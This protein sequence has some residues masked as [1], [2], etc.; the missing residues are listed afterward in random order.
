MCYLLEK[1]VKEIIRDW[2]TN[3]KYMIYEKYLGLDLELV[4][5]LELGWRLELVLELEVVGS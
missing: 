2:N 4:L 5:H 1:H 3:Y